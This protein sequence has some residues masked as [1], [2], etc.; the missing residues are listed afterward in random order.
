L[1]DSSELA[2]RG[3]PAVVVVPRGLA[4]LARQQAEFLGIPDF[5]L[6]IV[7]QSMYGR[8]LETLTADAA[9]LAPVFRAALCAG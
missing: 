7:E 8:P 2:K 6:A 3:V 5:P 9:A 4:E 1:R